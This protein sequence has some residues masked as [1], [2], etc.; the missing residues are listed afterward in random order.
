[1]KYSS[2]LLGRFF[3]HLMRPHPLDPPPLAERKA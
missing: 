3:P 1:L 2:V